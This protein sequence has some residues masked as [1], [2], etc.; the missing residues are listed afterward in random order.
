ME[1]N[2]N[3][4]PKIVEQWQL[5][6]DKVGFVR[7]SFMARKWYGAD[8][9]PIAISAV[10]LLFVITVG[11]SPQR[12]APYDPTAEVGPSFLKPGKPPPGY[13][14]ILLGSNHIQT[15]PDITSPVQITAKKNFI[16]IW[17]QVNPAGRSEKQLKR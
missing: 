3:D 4:T 13:E 17:W 6:L 9:S 16:G 7:K 12:Y 10:I 1:K 8:W 2:K 11:N 5:E 14:L 15:I